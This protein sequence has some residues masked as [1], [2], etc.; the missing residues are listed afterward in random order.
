M[1]QLKENGNF[2]SMPNNI[3]IIM[4]QRRSQTLT[5]SWGGSVAETVIRF[6][7]FQFTLLYGSRYQPKVSPTAFL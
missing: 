4:I 1:N 2:A 3:S 7:K 6:Q 5:S